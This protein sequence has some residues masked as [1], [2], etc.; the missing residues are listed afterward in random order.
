MSILLAAT[1]L[2]IVMGYS[3][4][5]LIARAKIS[6]RISFILQGA[7]FAIFIILILFIPNRYFSNSLKCINPPDYHLEN[8]KKEE[9]KRLKKSGTLPKIEV[10]KK[11]DDVISV[12]QFKIEKQSKILN[13]WKDF[14]TLMK[15]K[16]N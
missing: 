1:P 7:L 11:D 4:T 14:C 12:F 6:W 8:I 3:M 10:I 16:V 15:V 2:G 13:F 5:M 9:A